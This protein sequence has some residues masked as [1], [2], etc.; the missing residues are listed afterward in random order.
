MRNEIAKSWAELMRRL[1][2]ARYI[3]QSGDRGAL[4]TTKLAE[5]R[6]AGLAGIHL[7]FPQVIPDPIPAAQSPA[8]QRA[9]DALARF[10]PA[11]PASNSPSLAF[12]PA[13]LT[14][15][16]FQGHLRLGDALRFLLF[17]MQ[18]TWAIRSISAPIAR[19]MIID[20]RETEQR[21]RCFTRRMAIAFKSQRLPSGRSMA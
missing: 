21:T 2:Y 6:P 17:G 9:D 15:P 11:R 18:E 5:Q 3:A 12:S 10:Q 20:C 13:A 14:R 16:R 8:E 4:V 1:G 7:N 19:F